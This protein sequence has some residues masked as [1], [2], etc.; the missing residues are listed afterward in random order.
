MSR[1]IFLAVFLFL[2][3]AG[4]SQDIFSFVW[5]S[6]DSN[7]LPQNSVKSI[8]ADKYGYL[9]LATENGLVRYD[10]K[11][12]KNFNTQ[13]I[14]GATSNRM[15]FFEGSPEND[16]II[17]I[18]DVR[19]AFIINR[20]TVKPLGEKIIF[21]ALTLRDYRLSPY[22]LVPPFQF[23]ETSYLRLTAQKSTYIVGNDSIR[24]Y[25]RSG[26]LL[27]RSVYDCKY[28]SQFFTAGD[29]L[30]RAGNGSTYTRFARSRTFLGDFGPALS[31]GYKLYTNYA[32]RQSF[33][34]SEGCL[35]YIS[36]EAGKLSLKPVLQDFDLRGNNIIS[37]YY[38]L[39]NDILYLG[40]ASKG[41]LIVK[42]K[43][44][45][46]NAATYRHPTGTNGVYYAL[47]EFDNKVL[48]STGE[49][50]GPGLGSHPLIVLGQHT[51]KYIFA[52]DA[53][54]D[55]WTKMYQRLYRI[56]KAGGYQKFD[57]WNLDSAISSITASADGTVWIAAIDQ[58]R[59]GKGFLYAVDAARGVPELFMPLNFEPSYID[60]SLEG[61]IWAGA[62]D[63]LYS[64][65]LEGLRARKVAASPP[66]LIRSLYV[67]SEH[68]IWAATYEGGFFLY[69]NGKVTRF[70]LDRNQYLRTTHCLVEDN[71]GF[72]WISTNRG[73]FQISRK[74]LIGYSEKKNDAVYYHHYDKN[75][76]F[77]SN[78]FN[79]G[80]QPCGIFLDGKTIYFPSMDGIISFSPEKINP[81]LPYGE[82]Y[83]DEITVDGRPI[84]PQE[85]LQIDR[86]FSRIK[87]FISSPFYGNAYNQT[88]QVRLEGPVSQHW[89]DLT[90]SNVSF[91][92]L[93]PGNYTI[94]AKKL[95]GF[96]SGYAYASRKFTISRAF[97]Q[98]GWFALLLTAACVAFILVLVKLRIGYIRRKNVLLEKKVMLQ[99][100]QLRSTIST[101][102]KT[103]ADLH[104]Q[105]SAH[106]RLIKMVT[107]DIKS[108]LRFM[109]ITTSHLYKN[110][111]KGGESLLD[112]IYA[113]H[114]SSSQL[115][116]FVDSFLEY[117]KEAE[118]AENSP[119]SLFQLA[120]EKIA[121]FR[122][123][124]LSKKTQLANS[125][126]P[127]MCLTVNRHL[128]SIILHNL[129]DNAIKNTKGGSIE[130][131][132]SAGSSSTLVAV[133][134]SGRG[135][136][137]EQLQ[138]Y[139]KLIE[140]KS[141]GKPMPGMGMH[142]II[143]LAAILG[144][145]IH[146]DSAAGKGTTV[147]VSVPNV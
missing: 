132:A 64:I 121:M 4:Y 33:A 70:P 141:V 26:N 92:T 2:N 120:G 93:P 51:D 34:F 122:N 140:G 55:I 86:N 128:L 113:V 119:Y 95:R 54:G 27:Y 78:E 97:W 20:R 35:Y 8:V 62:S 67:K 23:P 91:S 145:R 36:E 107:H 74:D 60:A 7:H 50:F 131:S 57:E 46:H 76:G 22:T 66:F 40:S 138:Y 44:F 48:A 104:N 139:T 72:L 41:L 56:R 42:R 135:F 39:Q 142:M 118:A 111:G 147:T 3:L 37:F 65:T 114:S 47:A 13:N 52:I 126:P 12:L 108:P 144:A 123:I 90:E 79:G 75:S 101:L 134:D 29:N 146:L 25:A 84:I 99:T 14:S 83:I 38:D 129:L 15:T 58:K 103:R 130:F 6:A 116:H 110:Y 71:L 87:F 5:L 17:I 117:A 9:W 127:E 89:T 106:K 125:I 68:E 112:E 115:Y 137:S 19:E 133:R 45:A 143:E 11:D 124:A 85:G 109:E 21:P 96:G 1:I 30:Y 102:K 24:Q 28:L 61:R 80:C 53:K 10:G 49:F 82:I 73:L 16:S 63:G 100:S 105:I 81:S 69:R 59:R 31:K 136:T 88:I 43:R 94:T 77:R 98:T 18:N 32:A